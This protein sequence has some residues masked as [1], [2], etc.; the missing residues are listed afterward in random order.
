[1]NKI[2]NPFTALVIVLDMIGS[3]IAVA[4]NDY[5]SAI[6]DLLLAIILLLAL[7]VK[8]IVLKGEK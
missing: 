4:T 7:V 2:V 5:L 3:L 6:Y 1:M 8:A